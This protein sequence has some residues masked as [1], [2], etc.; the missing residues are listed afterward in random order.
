MSSWCRFRWIIGKHDHQLSESICRNDERMGGHVF[1][2]VHRNTVTTLLERHQWATTSHSTKWLTQTTTH[3]SLA[4]RTHSQ[5][6][7]SRQNSQMNQPRILLAEHMVMDTRLCQRMRNLPTEQKPDA[8]IED[9]LVQ[10]PIRSR[11]QTI[12]TCC[13]GSYHWPTVRWAVPLRSH[14]T[15]KRGNWWHQHNPHENHISS[16][17]LV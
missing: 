16:C 17:Q 10:N 9:P 7:R 14:S 11:S 12:L 15:C 2:Q 8:L 4:W 13:N 1:H 5:T 6:S 3:V